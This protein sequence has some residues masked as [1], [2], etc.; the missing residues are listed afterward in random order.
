MRMFLDTSDLTLDLQEVLVIKNVME[1]YTM[2][3]IEF[4][5]KCV[6]HVITLIFQEEFNENVSRHLRPHPGP[7]G[8]HRHEE[9][10]VGLHQVHD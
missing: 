4:M 8:G 10:H 3:M 5:K 6:I 2:Y 7:P 9:R 1:V